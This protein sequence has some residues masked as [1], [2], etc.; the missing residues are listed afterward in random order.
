[1]PIYRGSKSSLINTPSVSNYYGKDGLGDTGDVYPDL[2]PAKAENAVTAMIDYSK[3]YEGKI[4]ENS[5]SFNYFY[6]HNQI[7]ALGMFCCVLICELC[8]KQGFNSFFN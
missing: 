5:P 4:Y 6:K 2:V 8:N 3:M 7:R 1:M